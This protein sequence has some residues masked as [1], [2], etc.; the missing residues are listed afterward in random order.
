M[1]NEPGY[2][3]EGI[4]SENYSALDRETIWRELFGRSQMGMELQS[5]GSE[6]MWLES[7]VCPLSEI[8]IGTARLRD[9]EMERTRE[10][11]AKDGFDDF[12]FSIVT[13]GTALINQRNRESRLAAGDATL[14]ANTETGR[15][16]FPGDVG[17]IGIQ[18]SS[19]RLLARVPNA[20]E[21]IAA[22]VR[23]NCEPLRLLSS[24]VSEICHQ[25]VVPDTQMQ[26]LLASHV[27]DLVVLALGAD[28]D[29]EAYEEQ[30]GLK[31]ARLAAFKA[32]IRRH[33]T[34]AELSVDFLAKAHGLSSRYIAKIFAADGTTFS[35]YV[36]GKRLD[37]ARAMLTEPTFMSATISAIAYDVGFNDLSYFNR[38][39]KRRFG[40]SPGE[41]RQIARELSAE[42]ADVH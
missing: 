41:A 36:R 39:F 33:L 3:A 23:A 29:S 7:A 37:R 4:F 34:R 28:R 8:A 15:L 32:Y 16:T 18:I 30:Q 12:A 19:D 25:P 6:T 24:Y 13:G 31:A 21:A 22:P 9:V 35:D 38:C 40:M 5:L 27:E 2:D 14:T 42:E 11:I 26:H 17:F 20:Y 1:Q 10:L